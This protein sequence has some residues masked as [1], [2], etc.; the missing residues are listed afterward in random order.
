MQYQQNRYSL[1]FR[2]AG[3]EVGATE[4]ASGR[5]ATRRAGRAATE[6]AGRRSVLAKENIGSQIQS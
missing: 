6:C 3:G 4:Y 5:T 1:P 2:D